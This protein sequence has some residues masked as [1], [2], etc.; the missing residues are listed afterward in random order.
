M[1]LLFT[2]ASFQLYNFNQLRVLK[3]RH[4]R[5]IEGD[6]PV[7]SYAQQADI[8]RMR[9]QQ[10]RVCTCRVRQ[11][12]S[13]SIEQMHAFKGKTVE[14]RPAE[15]VAESRRMRGIHTN[16]LVHMER[17]YPSPVD[18]FRFAERR[19]RLVLRRGGGKHHVYLVLLV[20]PRSEMLRRLA[21]RASTHRCAAVEY[22]NVHLL[23]GKALDNAHTY[24]PF[25]YS[26]CLITPPYRS[27]RERLCSSPPGIFALINT[28]GSMPR[29]SISATISSV[30]Q[31][32]TKQLQNVDVEHTF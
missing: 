32:I 22:T 17:V 15:K 30:R 9:A 3:V 21:P 20:Q 24:S 14:Y 5:I 11:V 23:G 27:S 12:G 6:V 26:R 13:I 31:F 19:K 2:T 29:R 7:L 16:V 25:S 18:A 8:K 1:H 10:C 4:R 28:G